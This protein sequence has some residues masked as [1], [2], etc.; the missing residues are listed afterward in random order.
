MSR[1]LSPWVVDMCRITHL[2]I[3]WQ[4]IS[5]NPVEIQDFRR[6]IGVTTIFIILIILG[7]LLEL[8]YSFEPEQKRS[9]SKICIFW[10]NVP[11]CDSLTRTYYFCLNLRVSTLISPFFRSQPSKRESNPCS[12][13]NI[14]LV[15]YINLSVHGKQ[16]PS[17]EPV[18]SAL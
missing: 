4:E 18:L 3:W 17:L 7:H 13:V 8:S 1:K 12:R 11:Q 2:S 15:Y 9:C 16:E 6:K 14:R 5:S 10:P